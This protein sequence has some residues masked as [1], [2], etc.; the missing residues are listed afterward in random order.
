MTQV[1]DQLFDE[2]T[3]GDGVLGQHVLQA[4][5]EKGVA[6][7]SGFVEVRCHSFKQARRFGH[8][9]KIFSHAEDIQNRV[10]KLGTGGWN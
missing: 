6:L 9:T 5:D 8:V 1:G 2:T 7:C 4:I 10:P 3:N